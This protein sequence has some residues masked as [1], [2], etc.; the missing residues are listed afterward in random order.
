MHRILLPHMAWCFCFISGDSCQNPATTCNLI[1]PDLWSRSPS[2]SI[3]VIYFLFPKNNFTAIVF[4]SF[5]NYYPDFTNLSV[6]PYWQLGIIF[7]SFVITLTVISTFRFLAFVSTTFF[8]NWN[9][10]SIV[11]SCLLEVCSFIFISVSFILTD[12]LHPSSFYY[13]VWDD[14]IQNK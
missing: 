6:V 3:A 7:F 8:K 11:I 12:P 5:T 14:N 1:G 13:S 9:G 10:M 4:I 2:P